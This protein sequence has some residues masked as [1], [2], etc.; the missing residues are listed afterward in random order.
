MN[1]LRENVFSG[2]DA[3]TGQYL[4]SPFDPE[5]PGQL[6]DGELHPATKREYQWVQDYGERFPSR[7]PVDGVDPEKLS[8]SGWGI[9]YAPGLQD[10]KE[11]ERQLS[12]LLELRHQQAGDLYRSYDFTTG[13]SKYDFLHEHSGTIAG[14]VVPEKMPYY[15]LIVGDPESIPFRFQYELDV[16]YAVGRIH[17]GEVD[18]YGRYASQVAAVEQR[19]AE[20]LPSRE[21]AFFSTRRENDRATI[22]MNEDLVGP[23]MERLSRVDEK[24]NP[25]PWPQAALVGENATK[26]NLSN[27]LHGDH[28]PG[29]LF[30]ACHGVWFKSDKMQRRHQGALICQDWPGPSKEKTTVDREYCFSAGDLR[31]E[32]LMQGLIAVLFACYSAGTPQSSNFQHPVF[33]TARQIASKAFISNL[34]KRL[35]RHGAL[36]VVGHI[37]RSWSSFFRW[38]EHGDHLQP[39]ESM[40]TRLLQQHRLGYAMEFINQKYAEL[41]VELANRWEDHERLVGY[42]RDEFNRIWRATSDARNFVV[43]GDPAVYLHVAE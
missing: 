26:D 23:L 11:V 24:N 30:A 2:I 42:S 17:F 33:G 43:I 18:D 25:N 27:L 37:E 34:A 7:L 15:L 4:P 12:P 3:E 13:W 20:R 8:S 38:Q 35:L 31:S 9:I 16:Q 39:F 29:I 14:P 1:E 28:I 40:L 6:Y 5:S 36:A 41:A 21:I 10:R 22:L 32:V 19:K